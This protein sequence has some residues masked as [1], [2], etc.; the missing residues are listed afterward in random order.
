MIYLW[1]CFPPEAELSENWVYDLKFGD[2]ML[3]GINGQDSSK[4]ALSVW[5][6]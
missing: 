5:L 4:T 3:R 1:F 2:M 6:E